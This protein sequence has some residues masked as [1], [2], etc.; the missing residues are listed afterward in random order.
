[1][2]AQGTSAS[3]ALNASRGSWDGNSTNSAGIEQLGSRSGLGSSLTALLGGLV[4]L[5]VVVVLLVDSDLT[6]DAELSSGNLA[7]LGLSLSLG[8]SLVHLS[9][10]GNDVLIWHG[11]LV[12]SDG[13][14]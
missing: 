3:I 14:A 13:S 5:Q 7:G 9:L 10:I 8:N 4:T 1:L 2:L 12:G 6:V 11:D